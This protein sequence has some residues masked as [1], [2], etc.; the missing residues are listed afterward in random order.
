MKRSDKI[1]L[2]RY[3]KRLE[4]ARSA[5]EVNPF[6]TK[7]EQKARIERAKTDVKFMVQYYF[8]H[9]A[10]SECAD[11]QI[12][13]ANKVKSNKEFIGFAKW[14]RGQAKSVWNNVLI[15]F[16]LWMNE[17]KKYFVLI[18]QNEKR[19]Q[20]LLEDIRAEFEGNPRI[21]HDFGEQRQ[22][23]SW[24]DGF[25]IT[26]GGFIGQALGLGQSCRGLRVKEK[27]PDHV[28]CDDLETK[29]TIKNETIQTEHV[30]WFEGELLPAMDGEF[31]RA[32]ISN[33]WFADKMFIKKLA[34]RHEDWYVDEVVA[35]DSV[36]YEP[37]WY[38]KYD[39]EYFRKKE[40]KMGRAAALAEYCHE[41]SKRGTIFLPEDVQYRLI[42]KLN[43][44]KT[45]VGHWDVAY[46]GKPKS[47]YN[48]VRIW[49]LKDKDFQY[50][51]GFVKQCKMRAALDFMCYIN[52]N[53]PETVIIHWQYESQFWNDEVERTIEEAEEAAGTNL[54]LY[55]IDTPKTKKYD[56]IES[57]QSYWQN[58]RIWWNEQLKGNTSQLIGLDQYYGFGPGYKTKDDAPDA[59][60]QAITRLSKYI[61]KGSGKG[62]LKSGRMKGKNERI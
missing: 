27:R 39:N 61:P 25:F 44:Y 37:T 57:L 42:P 56:R 9:Y 18:G 62:K 1:A 34:E 33:N 5:G 4:F 12:N 29:K 10:T 16:W 8:P 36:T 40:K 19:A 48:A 21:I 55:Q 15:P 43:S 41:V 38:Q 45:I 20:Q 6:E 54:L 35:Y 46:S 23:G 28:N 32:T 31:E 53:L 17:G 59:D 49:G 47:D 14:G 24:E 30:E 51:N 58:G 26:K 13:W 7:A 52:K 22:I 50:I 11:F 2:D 60:H 3:K